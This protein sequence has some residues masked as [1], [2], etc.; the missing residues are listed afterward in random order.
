M[1]TTQSKNDKF[2]HEAAKPATKPTSNVAKEATKPAVDEVVS[3]IRKECVD[4]P[5]MY[6]DEVHV[7]GG[8]E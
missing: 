8:G 7:P 6:I 4:R 1:L 2:V 3:L 5:Q